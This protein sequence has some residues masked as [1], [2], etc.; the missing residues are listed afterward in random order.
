[1]KYLHFMAYSFNNENIKALTE[2]QL[3]KWTFYIKQISK[4]SWKNKSWIFYNLFG[5]KK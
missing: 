1:M 5:G 4:M 3:L 2:V